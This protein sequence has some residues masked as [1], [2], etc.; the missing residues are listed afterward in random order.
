MASNVGGSEQLIK[1]IIHHQKFAEVIELRNLVR[2]YQDIKSW[3]ILAP[4]DKLDVRPQLREK[5]A[6][7]LDIDRSI[8]WSSIVSLNNFLCNHIIQRQSQLKIE[9]MAKAKE[10]GILG[11]KI[12]IV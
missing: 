8:D 7:A 1:D 5:M 9:I 6:V 2:D 11:D 10:L 4:G 12:G 3:L